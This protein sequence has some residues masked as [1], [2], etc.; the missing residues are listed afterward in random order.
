VNIVLNKQQVLTFPLLL[1][2]S[3]TLAYTL[4][5]RGVVLP[6]GEG[7]AGPCLANSSSSSAAV[8]REDVGRALMEAV[9]GGVPLAWTDSVELL[10]VVF[11]D[12]EGSS[13][14]MSSM[15]RMFWWP[16]SVHTTVLHRA[17]KY[18]PTKCRNL[19][20]YI[21]CKFIRHNRTQSTFLLYKTKNTKNF[22]F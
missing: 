5:V 15:S 16:P 1:F 14:S 21:T 6:A 10:F 11:A 18:T 22:C 3:A 13:L 17:R 12:N 8:I 9:R 2:I 19:D 7:G 20:K 4:G